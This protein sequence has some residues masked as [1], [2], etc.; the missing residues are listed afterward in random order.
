MYAQ[1]YDECFPAQGTIDSTGNG[2][3][4]AAVIKTDYTN[5][6]VATPSW[7]GSLAPYMKSTKIFVCPTIGTNGFTAPVTYAANANVLSTIASGLLKPTETVLV[8]DCVQAT[9]TNVYTKTAYMNTSVMAVHSD[10]SNVGYIDGHVK[11]LKGTDAASTT[12]LLW[13]ADGS[14]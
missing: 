14:A 7:V 8:I 11:W 1:D 3:E 6:A 2:T 13:K 5:N 10:G 12:K 9:D 4:T